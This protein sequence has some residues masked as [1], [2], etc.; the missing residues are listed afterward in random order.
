MAAA[1]EVDGAADG[2]STSG[3]L[4]AGPSMA[5]AGDDDGAAGST[6][7][8]S[9]A[10]VVRVV[11]ELVDT[12]PALGS[13]SSVIMLALK[14]SSPKTSGLNGHKTVQLKPDMAFR[15]VAELTYAIPNSWAM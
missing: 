2:G 11:V 6:A 7:G 8:L 10:E 3:P 15:M 12:C 5:A 9:A 14:S 13:S 1:G 4:M